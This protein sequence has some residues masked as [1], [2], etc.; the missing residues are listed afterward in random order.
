MKQHVKS[1]KENFIFHPVL[2]YHNWFN[3]YGNVNRLDSNGL[4][5]SDGGIALSGPATDLSTPSIK[6]TQ[7]IRGCST[8]T[9]V[10]QSLTDAFPP[11]L[12]NI[13]TPKPLEL[14]S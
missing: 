13:I 6:Q 1:H 5:F 8:N 14:A 2:K 12:Q 10:I 3:I 9:F 4:T 7:C 11:N